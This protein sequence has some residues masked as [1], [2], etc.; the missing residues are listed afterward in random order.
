MNNELIEMLYDAIIEDQWDKVKNVVR[1]IYTTLYINNTRYYDGKML[2]EDTME[3]LL[4]GLYDKGCLAD[5]DITLNEFK[6]FMTE[7]I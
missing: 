4:T 2:E 7:Y 1:S 3:R 5:I 6:K